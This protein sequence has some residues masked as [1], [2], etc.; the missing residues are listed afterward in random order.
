MNNR[1]FELA[2]LAIT[3]TLSFTSITN[4]AHAS[5][6]WQAA[7]GINYESLRGNQASR[8]SMLYA[9]M[10]L[11]L[12]P[13]PSNPAY[14]LAETAFM[15]RTGNVSAVIGEGN[16]KNDY[17][18]NTDFR[19]LGVSADLIRPDIDVTLHLETTEA[20]YGEAYIVGSS[21]KVSRTL[22]TTGIGIGFFAQKNF[23]LGLTFYDSQIRYAAPSLWGSDNV[24]ETELSGKYVGQTNGHFYSIRADL[25]IIDYSSQTNEEVSLFGRYYFDKRQHLE[26]GF[27]ENIGD[28][29]FS[30]GVTYRFSV[31]T[32]VSS[33]A[34]IYAA[35]ERF[36]A[37][38]RW[39][40]DTTAFGLGGNIRF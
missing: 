7:A 22:D 39:G 25:R 17:F 34:S 14:P 33:K 2:T 9:D 18:E 13:L 19:L 32:F 5:E 27:T 16:F 20:D 40:E 12:S 30:E 4:A 8:G 11:H 10:T 24:T 38:H 21:T 15:E 26:I 6:T 31:G 35:L 1:V 37:S 36:S 29:H 28:D 23:H 3:A